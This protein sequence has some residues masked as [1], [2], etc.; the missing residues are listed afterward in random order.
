MKCLQ[1]LAKIKDDKNFFVV[2]V[3]TFLFGLIAH[4]YCYFNLLYTHDSVMVINQYG[5][6]GWQISLGRFLQAVYLRIR[7]GFYTPCLVG[8]L[9]LLFIALS[10]YFIL[11][12]L[13]IENRFLICLICGVLTVNATVILLNATFLPWLDIDMASLLSAIAG[14]YCV[15]EFHRGGVIVA[16]FFFFISLGLYQSFFQVA[17]GFL[18]ILSVKDI[19]DRKQT[20]EVLQSGLKAVI[21]LLA[22]LILYYLVLHIVL[23]VTGIELSTD[24]N[25]L[26]R[27]G[28]YRGITSVLW[29]IYETYHRVVSYFLHPVIFQREAMAFV[30]F[31]MIGLAAVFLIGIVIKKKIWGWN[32]FLLV[33]LILF[34]PFGINVVCF[35]SQGM[36]HEL[37]IYSFFF[38]YIFALYLGD[39][40]IREEEIDKIKIEKIEK[41]QIL[42]KYSIPVLTVVLLFNSIIF[43]NQTYLYKNFVYQNTLLVIER[44]IDRIEQTDGYVTGETPVAIVGLLGDSKLANSY[45]GFEKIG[46]GVGDPFSVTYYGTYI[47]YFGNLLRYPINLLSQ[48]QSEE[49]GK[50]EA[51]QEMPVFPEKGSC[52]MIDGTMVIKFS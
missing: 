21:S 18:M 32:L 19:L 31:V 20:K 45:A 46:I 50:T 9:S 27:V 11:K 28:Q 44:V 37:M 43:A 8:A 26:N 1:K 35:I 13:D 52:K 5:D 22:G 36:E 3:S 33:G 23:H 49:W 40:F 30:N 6:I 7:G 4:G 16:P 2:M 48:R 12:L 15:R 29:C 38:V 51:V 17:V 14:V 41:I 34:M 39:I 24:Y 42:Q 10:S 25:G 47:S